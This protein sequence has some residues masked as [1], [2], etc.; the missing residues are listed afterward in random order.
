MN[1]KQYAELWAESFR[2]VL[3]QLGVEEPKTEL[4]EKE[5]GAPEAASA[6]WVCFRAEG[7]LKGALAWMA[8]PATAKQFAQVLLSEPL[9]ASA[10]FSATHRDAHAEFM[11]QVA[12]QAATI[13]KAETSR[14]AQFPFSG[15]T[16][17]A[18]TLATRFVLRVQGPKFPEIILVLGFD[19]ALKG[20]LTA[21]PAPPAAAASVAAAA[22]PAAAAMPS[23]MDLLLD[24]ELE[25]TIRF[26]QREMTLR[27]VLGM[28]PGAVVELDR[29]VQEPAELL[30]SGRVVAKGEVVVVD[31]NFGLRVTEV[32]SQ[33]QRAEALRV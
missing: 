28:M 16:A 13:W 26:G 1:V 8:G 27:D 17:P 10:E 5:S 7:A 4:S 25:A 21:A 31:G 6:E 2:E 32:S 19:D 20:V 15:D 11:R 23:N 9:D 24:M 14:E 12:G 3:G 18:W 33:S 30:V 22:A 29:L